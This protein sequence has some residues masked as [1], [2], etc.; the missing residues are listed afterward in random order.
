MPAR[1]GSKQVTGGIKRLGPV[2]WRM[3]ASRKMES[4]VCSLETVIF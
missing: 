1:P 2:T 4:H 3:I